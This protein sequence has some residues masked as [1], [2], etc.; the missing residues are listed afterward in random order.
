MS[1]NADIRVGDRARHLRHRRHLSA[2]A[3]GRA[4]RDARARDRPDV[5]AD[6]LQ[7]ARRCRSQRASAGAGAGRP[8]CRRGPKSRPMPD[9]ARKGGK[10]R[11]KRPKARRGWLSGCCRTSRRSRRPAPR[12]SCAR[13]GRGS[14][15]S[16]LL[17]ALLANLAAARAASRWCCDPD[18]LALVLLY[19]CIQ[20]A[21]PRRRRRRLVRRPADGRRAT[22]RC[23]AS[24]RSPTRCSPTRAEYFRRRVLRFPLW[25]QAAQ[26]AVLLMLCAALV[27]LVRVVGGAPLPRWTYAVPPLVGALLWPLR[28]GRC[29]SGRSVRSARRAR[30]LAA[31]RSTMRRRLLFQ[32]PARPR[33]RPR[34]RLAGAAQSRARALP[35][36]APAVVAGVL[37]VLAFCGLVRALLLPAGHPARA[38]SRRSPRPTASRSCRSCPTA[39][40]SPTATASCSRRATRRIR[41]R[42]RRRASKNLDETIDALPTIVDVAAARPQAL[43]AS[44]SRNRRISRACRCARA[45]PTRR[46]RASP[47][48]ATAFRASRSRRACS[49]STRSARSRRTSSATS[50]ASTTRTSS[51]STS[52]T[53]CA[54]YKG[55]DY[56]GKVGVELVLRARAARHDRRRGGR[57]R[58]RRARGADAVAHAADRPATT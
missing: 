12:K 38:L 24:M 25:Q 10:A 46:S 37:V 54:N 44:C 11:R 3:R 33:R 42:S 2:G 6:R 47:S 16:T 53:R 19:W 31:R 39:A 20:R 23:S 34:L 15:R 28:L 1:P 51:A 55:S 18:F 49:A 32:S 5:R 48:T 22:R 9:A 50:A 4:G 27:L 14:S 43:Q 26:V 58:R 45:F 52:G 21:A 30:P 29:C 40:S 7:A 36:Q 41:S 13:R 8:R 17:L 57:G 56:I 35:V